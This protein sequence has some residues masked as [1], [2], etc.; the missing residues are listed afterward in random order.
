MFKLN[1]KNNLNQYKTET[2]YL[3]R[4]RLGYIKPT[5]AQLKEIASPSGISHKPFGDIPKHK[6]TI[7]RILDKLGTAPDPNQK[8][9][10]YMDFDIAD[11]VKF[12]QPKDTDSISK[13]ATFK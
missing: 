8:Q 4:S 1:R 2:V 7:T 3:G 13:L 5:E 9:V 11:L 12:D 10:K 6:S